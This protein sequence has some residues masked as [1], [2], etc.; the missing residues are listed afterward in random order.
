MLFL[1]ANIR[2]DGPES[3]GDFAELRQRA[4][5]V[6][7]HA[8]RAEVTFFGVN[9]VGL[10]GGLPSGLDE[11]ASGTGG[12]VISGTELLAENLGKIL[13]KNLGYYSLGYEAQGDE[14]RPSPKVRVRVKRK[15]L[16]VSNRPVG[17]VKEQAPAK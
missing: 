4:K 7:E 15:G 1:V 10:G 14:K 6:I 5:G 12:S 16:Q 13:D 2:L 17:F 11:F 3:Q 8:N 9:P